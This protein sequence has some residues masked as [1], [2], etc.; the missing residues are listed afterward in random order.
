V[1]SLDFRRNKIYTQKNFY[2]FLLKSANK[3]KTKKN[4]ILF[5]QRDLTQNTQIKNLIK[6]FYINKQKK[7]G[8]RFFF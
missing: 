2:E 7:Y 5:C 8:R 3:K 1:L 6:I 4:K